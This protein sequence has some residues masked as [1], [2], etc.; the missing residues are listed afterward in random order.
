[1]QVA[2]AYTASSSR[3][4]VQGSCRAAGSTLCLGYGGEVGGGRLAESANRSV[5]DRVACGQDRCPTLSPLCDLAVSAQRL[6]KRE[7]VL[8]KDGS[9]EWAQVGS[10]LSERALQASC[11]ASLF[12]L[13]GFRWQLDS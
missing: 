11:F 3:A 8:A 1:M 13:H 5:T 2:T 9:K 12:A 7:R 10:R 4:G 6:A